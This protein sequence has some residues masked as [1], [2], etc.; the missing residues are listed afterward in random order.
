MSA[1]EEEKAEAPVAADMCASPNGKSTPPMLRAARAK[2]TDGVRKAIQEV[3][4]IPCEMRDK[5]HKATPL[6]WAAYNGDVEALTLLIDNGA[7][8]EA[9][10]VN[11][12]T[13]LNLAG[14]MGNVDC[15][16]KLIS[17]GATVDASNSFKKT[18]LLLAAGLGRT[19]AAKVLLDA[20]ANWNHRDFNGSNA[21]DRAREEDHEEVRKL[22][23]EVHEKAQA[24]VAP[25][26]QAISRNDLDKLQQSLAAIS[27]VAVVEERDKFGNSPLILAGWKGNTEAIRLLLD[28]K[29]DIEAANL[30]GLTPLLTAAF[31]G[32]VEAVQVLLDAGAD[33]TARNKDGK[34]ALMLAREKDREEVVTLLEGVGAPGAA[35]ASAPSAE[36]A[37]S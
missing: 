34:S 32:K 26:L 35:E 22:L 2:D 7:N 20:G 23:E 1:K 11:G 30:T 21:L 33:R 13:A 6:A 8:L 10:N 12:C 3:G 25:V 28:A 16:K 17:S 5:K 18:P 15:I 29:A 37:I 19:E 24:E 36:V 4:C 31:Y 14:G 9:G 27:H